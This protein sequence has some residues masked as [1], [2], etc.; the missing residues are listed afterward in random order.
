MRGLLVVNPKA[1]TTTDV[2]RDVLISAL[3]D[4]FHLEVVTTTHRGHARELGL[5]ARS[6][7]MDCILTLGGD[8][9]VHEV[10]NGMLTEGPGQELPVLGTVPGG[11]A[12]VFA[13]A[14]GFPQDAVES[15]GLLLRAMREGKTRTINLGQFDDTYFTFTA[16]I[17]L[18]AEIM[19]RMEQAR[20]AGKSA[21]PTR[22]LA[23]TLR[24]FF[25][26]SDRKEPAL[27]L[28]APGEDP[29]EG[30]FLVIIQNTS[31]WTYFGAHPIN[32]SPKASF[33][34]GLDLWGTKSLKVPTAL[35][36]GAR[37][38]FSRDRGSPKPII[39][40]HDMQEFRITATRP[41]P[42]QVD[43]EVVGDVTD[44]TFRSVPRALRVYVP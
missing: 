13:R 38:V 30:V 27:I 35:R 12:N 10:V 9:T 34:D 14:L 4:K 17:G 3:A 29:V 11:S 32:P 16:G 39:A 44:I 26:G 1:T 33:D 18:D 2:T 5:Q 6:E 37:M 15:T 20:A 36:H 41:M 8:G 31:P 22:Y 19:A 40:W 43:G 21:S 7:A 24:Q 28:H 42:M 25:G 23:T